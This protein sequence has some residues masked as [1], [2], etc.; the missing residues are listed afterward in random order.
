MLAGDDTRGL[1]AQ[2][3]AA[4]GSVIGSPDRGAVLNAVLALPPRQREALILRYHQ[5][6]APARIAEHMG[7]KKGTVRSHLY[8]GLAALRA[9]L[10]RDQAALEPQ[11]EHP[12]SDLPAA[13]DSTTPPLGGPEDN[14]GR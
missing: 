12:P 9:V 7:I 3:R 14:D 1:L 6:L 10:D 2:L 4:G 11:D 5:G 8:R 13:A